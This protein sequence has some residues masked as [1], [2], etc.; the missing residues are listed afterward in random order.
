MTISP[1]QARLL[2]RILTDQEIVDKF[3][4]S[5]LEAVQVMD[6]RPDPDPKLLLD[7]LKYLPSE[8]E[9]TSPQEILL[10]VRRIDTLG[11]SLRPSNCL[12]KADIKYIWQLVEKTEDQLLKIN[13]F[14]REKC[15]LEVKEVLSRL[16]LFLDEHRRGVLEASAITRR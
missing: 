8:S 11:L 2:A 12:K 13:H 6:S 16:G 1:D 15:L 5:A 10:L 3:G 14:G 9:C 4:P 7:L